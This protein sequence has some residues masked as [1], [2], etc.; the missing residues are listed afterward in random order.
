EARPADTVSFIFR[1][2]ESTSVKIKLHA[3]AFNSAPEKQLGYVTQFRGLIAQNLFAE[4]RKFIEEVRDAAGEIDVNAHD[5]QYQFTFLHVASAAGLDECVRTLLELG[6]DVRARDFY[7]ATPLH[8]AAAARH[9]PSVRL[10]LEAG[11]QVDARTYL[12]GATPLHALF[13]HYRELSMRDVVSCASKHSQLLGDVGACID[14]LLGA[15]AD[16][17]ARTSELDS[18]TEMQP[19][20]IAARADEET[21]LHALLKAGAQLE[22]RSALG[23]TPLHYA[24]NAYATYETRCVV[25]LLQLGA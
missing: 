11:A 10:L 7:L 18:S 20:H 15:G 21:A 5:G 2:R 17:N 16:V 6:A 24:A 19:L 4:A 9:A 1:E 22:A 23:Q 14:A 25:A 12:R 8:Y 13:L 3:M